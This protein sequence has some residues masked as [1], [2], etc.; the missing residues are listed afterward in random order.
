MGEP[1]LPA[2]GPPRP[3]TQALIFPSRTTG[4]GL[5]TLAWASGNM[6]SLAL[7]TWSPPSV[8]NYIIYVSTILSLSLFYM[9]PETKNQPHVDILEQFTSY[10]R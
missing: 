1:L 8:T 10:R 5:L 9:L 2:F 6:V 4:L 7:I 3:L